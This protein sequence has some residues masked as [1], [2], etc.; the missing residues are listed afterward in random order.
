MGSM[1][2]STVST[3]SI[4]NVTK[5]K[6][7]ET[8]QINTKIK[9]STVKEDKLLTELELEVKDSPINFS[10]ELGYTD[11]ILYWKSKIDEIGFK[12]WYKYSFLTNTSEY[13]DPSSFRFSK[14][15]SDSSEVIN[16]I[17]DGEIIV[18]VPVIKPAS[19]AFFKLWELL[20]T[21]PILPI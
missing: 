16:K 11:N 2:I 1:E 14:Q 18:P 17:Y 15:K 21:F 20:H 4:T 7:E 13:L 12:E 19:R 5:F 10:E 9:G 6:I 8:I 3:G